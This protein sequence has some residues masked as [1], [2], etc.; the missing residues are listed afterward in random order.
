MEYIAQE[1]EQKKKS[2]SSMALKELAYQELRCSYL[3]YNVALLL[4]Y[5]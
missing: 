1:I 2:K 3:S 4:P 5:V